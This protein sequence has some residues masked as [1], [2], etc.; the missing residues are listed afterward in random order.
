MNTY[1]THGVN[2]YL[3]NIKDVDFYKDGFECK[4]HINNIKECI[5][6]IKEILSRPSTY[7]Y[8]VHPVLCHD[9]RVIEVSTVKDDLL[10]KLG[11]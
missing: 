6:A 8:V 2:G 3:I 10:P 5:Y 4:N 9:G 7:P 11:R 1:V